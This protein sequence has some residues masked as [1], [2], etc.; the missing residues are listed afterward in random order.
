MKL[1]EL[2]KQ[3]ESQRLEFKESFGKE[4]VETVAAF[5][6]ASGGVILIGVDMKGK[7][8][9]IKY[10][11]ESIKDWA[12]MI[13]QAT[14]PQ[15]FPEISP[16]L[17]ENKWI[18]SVFVQEYPV[19]PVSCK[20]KYFKRI[21]ASNHQIP[22]C[23]IVEMQ[24]FSI[25]NSFVSFLVGDTLADLQMVRVGNFFRIFKELEGNQEITFTF[26]STNGMIRSLLKVSP[27]PTESNPPLSTMQDAIQDSMQ[28]TMQV[29]SLVCAV[30]GEM[31]RKE[32][33]DKLTLQN[34]D[35]FR[36]SYLIPALT[37][38]LVELTLPDKPNS[39]NQKYRLTEK[40]VKMKQKWTEITN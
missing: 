37:I 21:G 8:N 12:N 27:A 2:M 3:G 39:K 28:A 11:E 22:V 32:I 15:I 30:T 40:G 26:E 16:V 6:N 25:N 34:R 20:G 10:Y 7:V 9:G 4:T 14:L 31:S 23:E 38:G 29:K 36:K 13:K 33:Q 1:D 24:L 19:K 35:Y 18:V 5:S 17:V